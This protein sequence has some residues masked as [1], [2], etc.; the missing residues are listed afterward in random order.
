MKLPQIARVIQ[1]KYSKSTRS[2]DYDR[3]CQTRGCKR[4]ATWRGFCITHWRD[5][6]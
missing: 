2:K 6:R 4:A 5:G 1:P 3:I